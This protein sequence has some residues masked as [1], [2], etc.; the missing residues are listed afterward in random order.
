VGSMG[1]QCD[2]ANMGLARSRTQ[3][4]ASVTRWC[5]VPPGLLTDRLHHDPLDEQADDGALLIEWKG[6][7]LGGVDRHPVGR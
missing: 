5:P 2:T 6:L 7:P 3:S 1:V 4:S